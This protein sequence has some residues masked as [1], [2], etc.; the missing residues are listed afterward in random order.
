[1]STS[2]AEIVGWLEARL[3]QVATWA[4]GQPGNVW[5]WYWHHGAAA[6]LTDAG[7]IVAA[8]AA[9]VTDRAHVLDPFHT[10]PAGDVAYVYVA[11]ADTS[12]GLRGLWAC[13]ETLLGRRP[14]IA[15]QR[16]TRG[17][18][19]QLHPYARVA[20]LLNSTQREDFTHGRRYTRAA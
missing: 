8:G 19:L 6:V 1:M 13:M 11:A 16:P 5:R 10:D 12:E 20:R 2:A 7:R 18:G 17:R 3:P 15:W 4:Y 9:R 14:W